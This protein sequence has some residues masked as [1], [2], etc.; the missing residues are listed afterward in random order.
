MLIIGPYHLKLFVVKRQT[1]KGWSC[2]LG[3]VPTGLYCLCTST[4]SYPTQRSEHTLASSVQPLLCSSTLL[5]LA[6]SDG[7]GQQQ[8][9]ATSKP[10]LCT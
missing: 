7:W 8:M 6:L 9:V 2:F 1:Q 3:S 5:L 4:F 10:L